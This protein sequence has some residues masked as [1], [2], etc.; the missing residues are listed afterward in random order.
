MLFGEFR[1]RIR[2]EHDEEIE[3]YLKSTSGAQSSGACCNTGLKSCSHRGFLKLTL[4]KSNKA[5]LVA[6]V[7]SV[8]LSLCAA[9]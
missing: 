5:G 3:A 6:A 1:K 2:R 7:F 9:P 4:Q 8:Q